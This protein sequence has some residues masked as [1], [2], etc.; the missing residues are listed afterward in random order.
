MF[1]KFTQA[2][3]STTRKYGG[4]GLGLAISKQLAEIMGGEIGIASEEGQGSEFWFTA[5][6]GKQ[7]GIARNAPPPVQIHG[8]HILVVDDSPT[9]REILAAQLNA[10]GT[11]SEETCDGPSALLALERARDAGDPFA[12]VIL[13]M[14]M[15]GMDG[16]DLARAIKSDKTLAGTILVLMTSMGQR[17]DARHMQEL[18]FAAYL[19]KPARQSDL[20]DCLAA[21]LAGTAAAQPVKPI[22]TRHAIREMRRGAIRILLAEDNVT[23]QQV[24]LGILGK[25]GLQADA[26]GNGAEAVAAL[27]TLAYDLVLMDVQMPEMDGF[28]ATC[29]IRD[30]LSAVRNHEIPIIAMTAHAMQGDRQRCLDAGMN[31]YV[32]KPVSPQA[33]S[34]ALT[35]WLPGD[36][37]AG[38]TDMPAEPAA[39]VHPPAPRDAAAPI[40]AGQPDVPVFDRPALLARMM[41]DE[42]LA[43]SVAAGFL[44]DIPTQIETL[45]SYLDARDTDGAARQAHTIKGASANV[46]GES[47]RAAAFEMEK[48][49][50]AGDLAGTAAR[51]PDLDARFAALR[52][53]MRAFAVR[54]RIGFERADVKILIADDDV[55]SRLVLSGVL[56]KHGHEVVETVNG[57]EAWDALKRPDAP[58]LAILDR[59]MPGLSG[60]DVCR[61]A[62]AVE[63]SQPSYIILLTSLDQKA[64]IVTGL[65][66]GA[67]DYLAK[68]FDPGEL[69]ARVDVGRRLVEL[70]AK[71]DEAREALVHEAMHDPL[72]GVLNRRAF[73]GAL[74]R[75]LS[76]KRRYENVLAVGICDIDYFK[77]INDTYGHQTGDEVLCGLV[78]LIERNLRGHDVLGRH[79]GDEFVVVTEHRREDGP[80]IL[81]ERLRSSVANN[82]MSTGAGDIQ[83]TIS[84][85]VRL[86]DAGD[87]EAG[88]LAA[89]DKALYEAKAEGRNRVR[90][91]EAQPART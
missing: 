56:R 48:A 22:I 25:L 80:G 44:D 50:R 60:V 20:F 75:E 87:T 66:A 51:L 74:A 62:R 33:L 52:E 43:R 12:A 21:V 70:Q 77:Q 78:R 38:L 45:R 5:R 37:A 32:T 90:L 57:L 30:P 76:R 2:D 26:V 24:A 64:D 89:A 17:G 39:A 63:T 81:Y 59:V 28:E 36:D 88:L 7:M 3:A 23:N 85:G 58:K 13:D 47:L 49:A 10:W 91:A 41:N 72:T 9:N 4:T 65:E 42:E 82:P 35:R 40:A 16:E 55:T 34:E 27:E 67:D 68:P 54:E 14:Q 79:G 69:L 61:R 18:G 11:R 8:V 53:A 6:F 15:P 83:I 46:G 73:A 29:H 19:V 1:Q 86:V 84:F 31:D 71:L